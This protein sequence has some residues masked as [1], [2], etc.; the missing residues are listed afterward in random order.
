MSVT[1]TLVRIK[2]EIEGVAPG[3]IFQSKGIMEADEAHGKP[4]KPRPPEEEAKLRAHWTTV[5][6]KK[7]LAIPWVMLYQSIC[8]AG[9][10]F[11]A[12]AKMTFAQ[13]LGPTIS[14]EQDKI[15]LDTDKFEVMEEWVKI[16]PKTG[17]MVR[18]GRPLIRKWKCSF[19]ILAD[20]EAY[21][22]NM[23]EQIIAYAGKNVGIGAWRPQLKGPYG[24]FNLV[25][26]SVED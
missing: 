2:V 6:G 20:A 24:K 4:A 10:N 9:G 1:A 15:P 18:I 13:V 14:C 19:N 26:F 25:K 11:K 12:K 22:P 7:R 21:N 8:K 17:A 16:P 5:S 3:L 23:L